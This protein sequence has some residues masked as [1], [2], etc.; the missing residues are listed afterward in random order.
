MIVRVGQTTGRDSAQA[1]ADEME[2]D[3]FVPPV[4]RT[5]VSFHNYPATRLDG[6][7]YQDNSPTSLH[8]VVYIFPYRGD[9]MLVIFISPEAT[10]ET[11][12]KPTADA[13]MQSVTF[14]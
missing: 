7:E 4:T 8:M 2:Q 1:T 11:T 5:Q 9:V 3:Y 10:W 6:V 13:I 12:G 14:K